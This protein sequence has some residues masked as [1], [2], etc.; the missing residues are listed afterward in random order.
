M[1]V[2][3]TGLPKVDQD[4]LRVGDRILVL[5]KKLNGERV[6]QVRDRDGEVETDGDFYSP[7]EYDFYRVKSAP[8][9]LPTEAG[10]VIRTSGDPQESN[11]M[12]NTANIWV[13]QHGGIKGTKYFK[14]YIE[15]QGLT[16]EVLV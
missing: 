5:P 1:T 12:L 15:N 8:V 3:I 13:S 2:E 9:E 11:W 10:S 6:I 14:E 16:I 4:R 7:D